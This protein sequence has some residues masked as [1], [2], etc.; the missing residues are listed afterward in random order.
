MFTGANEKEMYMKILGTDE[1]V[2]YLNRTKFNINP[3][4][5][6]RRH[7]KLRQNIDFQM[8]RLE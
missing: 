4:Q 5:R 1:F 3:V 7:R 2:A 8:P 6:V